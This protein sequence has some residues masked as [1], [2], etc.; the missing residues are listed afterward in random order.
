MSNY[1]EIDSTYRD[2]NDYPNP[3]EFTIPPDQT[4]TWYPLRRV[5]Q[6]PPNPKYAA[7][8]R[9][10]SITLK[11]LTIPYSPIYVAEPRMYIDLHSLTYTDAPLIYTIDDHLNNARFACAQEKIQ[12]DEFGNPVWIHYKGLTNDQTYRF[13]SDEA[14]YIRVFTRDGVTIPIADTSIPDPP[15]PSQQ[16]IVSFEV[17]PYLRDG[18]YEHGIGDYLIKNL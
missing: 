14:V 17:T 11:L 15:D 2:R 8:D 13:K 6:N 5:N 1:L 10:Q 4:Q 9:F 7:R 12:N 18:D 16:I 3:A